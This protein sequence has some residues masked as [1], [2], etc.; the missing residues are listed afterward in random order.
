MGWDPKIILIHQFFGFNNSFSS[1]IKAKSSTKRSRRAHHN[2][3]DSA[4]D[5]GAISL[6][7]S[8]V[9]PPKDAIALAWAPHCYSLKVCLY[10]IDV[11]R[12]VSPFKLLI[13]PHVTE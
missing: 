11:S 6:V 10:I 13:F 3:L 4:G 5:L 12:S 8:V 7:P 2:A 9:C 1:G